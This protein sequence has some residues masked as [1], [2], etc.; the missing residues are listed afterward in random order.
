MLGRDP[1]VTWLPTD[2]TWRYARASPDRVDRIAD[3][4]GVTVLCPIAGRDHGLG[5]VQVE[6]R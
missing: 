3:A 4:L 5:P 1:V 2:P 6:A